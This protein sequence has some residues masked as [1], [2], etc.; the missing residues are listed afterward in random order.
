MAPVAGLSLWQFTG[1]I[2][3]LISA[4]RRKAA[5]P[6]LMASGRLRSPERE[7]QTTHAKET[8]A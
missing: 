1:L 8:H 2:S 3:A 6:V 5:D 4:L 7:G